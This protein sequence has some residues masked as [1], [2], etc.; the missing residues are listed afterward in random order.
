MMTKEKEGREGE[1]NHT[2]THTKKKK[3]E[4]KGREIE[5]EEKRE[6][7]ISKNHNSKVEEK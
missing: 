5:R 2:N 1:D 4:R 6:R 3:G 7:G